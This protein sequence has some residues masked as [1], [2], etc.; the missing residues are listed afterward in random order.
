VEIDGVHATQT[1]I[2][3]DPDGDNSAELW[4]TAVKLDGDPTQLFLHVEVKNN[5]TPAES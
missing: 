2:D 5:S 1:L 4:E 3:P